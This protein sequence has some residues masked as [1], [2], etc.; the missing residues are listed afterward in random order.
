M[1]QLMAIFHLH[2]NVIDLTRESNRCITSVAE[3]RVGKLTDNT[4]VVK[5]IV[6]VG[7]GGIELWSPTFFKISCVTIFG[8]APKRLFQFILVHHINLSVQPSR[9][10]ATLS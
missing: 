1:K 2:H 8:T 7:L 5:F 10:S 3:Y 9:H 6:L 4:S